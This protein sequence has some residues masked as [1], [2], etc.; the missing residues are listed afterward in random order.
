VSRQLSLPRIGRFDVTPRC[1][2]SLKESVRRALSERRLVGLRCRRLVFSGQALE[3][4]IVMAGRMKRRRASDRRADACRFS[5][6]AL[7][8]PDDAEA[9]AIRRRIAPSVL[10]NP[11]IRA[12]I[13]HFSLRRPAIRRRIPRPSQKPTPDLAS[14]QRGWGLPPL[15]RIPAQGVG[16]TPYVGTESRR[17]RQV[18]ALG[19]HGGVPP[20]AGR[21]PAQ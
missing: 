1:K 3:A 5:D 8:H 10:R 19:P 13:A 17:G 11:A 7:I 4:A 9:L 6:M 15:P 18:P 16:S 12:R 21:R 14:R 2:S 20:K